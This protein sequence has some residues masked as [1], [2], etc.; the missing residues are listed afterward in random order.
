MFYSLKQGGES[1]EGPSVRL[2]EIF[3]SVYGNISCGAKIIEI[4]QEHVIVAGFAHDMETNARVASEE[5]ASIITKNGRRYGEAMIVTTA[6]AA[7]AKARR[8]ALFQV[9][10]RVFIEQVM[11]AAK[12][13][14]AGTDRPKTDRWKDLSTRFAAQKVT[15]KQALQLIDRTGFAEMTDEDFASLESC[16]A[17]IIDREETIDS[18][19]AQTV[20]VEQ[21][22]RA[23]ADVMG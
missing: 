21:V 3:F 12:R 16:L 6:K 5:I 2:A 10:P 7:M 18:L 9:I 14:A 11:I 15:D 4:T 20:K 23:A 8:N 1:I 19:L 13:V 22:N 17:Q